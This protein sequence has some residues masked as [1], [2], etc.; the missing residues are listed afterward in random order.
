VLLV[1][2]IEPKAKEKK[3]RPAAMFLF[4]YPKT[5]KFLQKK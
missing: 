5:N 4:L 3:L 1:A 2:V